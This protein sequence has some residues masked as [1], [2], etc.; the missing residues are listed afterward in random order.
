MLKKMRWRFIGAAMAAFSAVVLILLLV[1]NFWN[2]RSVTGQLDDTIARLPQNI[3]AN[4]GTPPEPRDLPQAG[5]PGRFSPE[6]QYMLR[7]F[8]VHCNADGNVT[9]VDQD[10]IASISETDAALYAAAALRS[11]S[12]RGYRDGY[13]YLMAAQNGETV[14][15][16]LNAEREVQAMRSLL[17]ITCVIAAGCLLIVFALI[18][19]FSRRAI[20]PYAR[21]IAAQKQF[22]T[23]ASHELKTPLTAISTSADVLDM[24]YPD[25]EWV[26]NIQSQAAK[27]SKL[28]TSL[29]TLSRLDEENPLPDKSEFSLSD[30]V[31]E[32]A[33]PF[34]SLAQA[35]GLH[36]SQQIDDN[37]SVV[38]DRTSIQ[39]MASI[40]LDNAVKYTQSGG[41]IRLYVTKTGRKAEI[42]VYNTYPD[43]QSVDVTRLFD[44]FYRADQSHSG[45]ISGAGIGLSIAKAT[46]EAHGGTIRAERKENGFLFRVRL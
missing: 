24:E 11:G 29:V 3:Q 25:D 33:E 31:W 32:I 15:T 22:I 16:F 21:N 27:L 30:A 8:T 6:V 36:Y 18:L 10:Y 12:A 4:H 26:K 39:Q 43:A 1:I 34:A 5:E 41:E 38:G 2:Y 46:A 45:K 13:R 23:N 14:I 42:S 44:R 9:Q 20:A 40:L 28:I 19:L 7:F 37:T 35:R 17:V